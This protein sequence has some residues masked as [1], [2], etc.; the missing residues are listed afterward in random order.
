MAKPEGSANTNLRKGS[1]KSV[2]LANTADA[3][4]PKVGNSAGRET[5]A[6]SGG[7]V[8]GVPTY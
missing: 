2:S 3:K 4:P 5:R 8:K 6:K 7:T 1:I